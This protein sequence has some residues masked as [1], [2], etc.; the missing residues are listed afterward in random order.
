VASCNVGLSAV[1][2]IMQRNY[3]LKLFMASS[4]NV[5]DI[6]EAETLKGPKLP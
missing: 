3:Q 1:Y 6:L 5:K 2:D 4:V